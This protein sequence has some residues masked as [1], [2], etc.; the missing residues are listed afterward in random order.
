MTDISDKDWTDALNYIKNNL[1][2]GKPLVLVIGSLGCGKSTVINLIN[3]AKFK[4]IYDDIYFEYILDVK[5]DKVLAPIEHGSFN[6][7]FNIKFYKSE[8]LDF[9][10]CE[11]VSS[12]QLINEDKIKLLHLILI[13]IPIISIVLVQR[14]SDIMRKEIYTLYK[15]MKTIFKDT[16]FKSN[17]IYFFIR[18]EKTSLINFKNIIKSIIVGKENRDEKKFLRNL[19]MNQDFDN[20]L[21]WMEGNENVEDIRGKLLEQI[22]K[23][24]KKPLLSSQ[25]LKMDDLEVKKYFIN[26]LNSL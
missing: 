2:I 15:D 26:K 12:K 7:Y 16:S 13:D 4:K 25:L 10:F 24:S 9:N 18:N 14:L 22:N 1:D 20:T 5:N 19:E 11:I 8:S 17:F 21:I 23:Y 6:D 3:G